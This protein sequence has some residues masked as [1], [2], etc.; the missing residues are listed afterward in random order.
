M[1][2]QKTSRL[3][4]KKW[5]FKIESRVRGANH[6]K[7]HGV[8]A[9]IDYCTGQPVKPGWWNAKN[10]DKP[11][12]LK[13]ARAVKPYLDKELQYRCEGS[14][15]NIYCRDKDLLKEL[16][17][18]LKPWVTQVTEPEDDISFD[19]LTE[20]TGSKVLCNEYPW[21]IY[22]YKIVLRESMA[23]ETRANFLTWCQKFPEKIKVANSSLS[24]LSNKKMWLQ[25]PF[26]YVKDTGTCSMALLFLGKDC[27]KVLQYILKSS[28]NTPCPH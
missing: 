20:N 2:Y 13:F 26:V 12:L 23:P 28:I 8:D 4:Y 21:G 7:Y 27:S 1:R 11:Q 6:I 9:V 14:H 18:D 17:K 19:Y 10:I 24:W 16:L 3:F 25:Q 22:E 15:F 5:P